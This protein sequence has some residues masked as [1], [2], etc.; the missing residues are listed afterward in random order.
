MVLFLG[1]EVIKF[2]SPQNGVL[3]ALPFLSRY[4]FGIIF[5]QFFDLCLKKRCMSL[6]YLRKVAVCVCMYAYFNCPSLNSND[7]ELNFSASVARPCSS[8]FSIGGV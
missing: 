5:A 8:G 2:L 4:T 7:L 6:V 1:L 3:S